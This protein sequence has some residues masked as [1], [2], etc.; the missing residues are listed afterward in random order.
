MA[1]TGAHA[2]LVGEALVT[3]DNVEERAREFMLA[4]AEAVPP[5]RAI[6]RSGS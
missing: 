6:D 2:L 1:N 3:G 5:Q 4:Q